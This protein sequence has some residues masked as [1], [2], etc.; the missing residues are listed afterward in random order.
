MA[1][2]PPASVLEFDPSMRIAVLYGKE[3]FLIE[4]HTRRLIEMLQE[5]FGGIEVFTFDGE[6]VQPA[7]VLDELRS[8]GLM[9]RH[10]L[11]ILNNAEMFLAGSK[12][13][14]AEADVDES[15]PATSA[16]AS[17]SRR[18]LMERYAENPVQD[19]TLLMRASTWRAG[20][21]DKVILKAGGVI[22]E[23]APLSSDKAAAWCIKRCEKRYG[24]TIELDAAQ[25]LVLRLGPELQHLDTELC[26]LAAMAGSRGM[27]RITRDI[28]AQAVGLSREEKAWEIQEAVV[29]GDAA[30]MLHKLRELM[31]VSR[32]D[33]VPIAWA[34]IDLLR[35]LYAAAQLMARGV[36]AGG[37]TSQLRLW[38]STI[39]PMLQIA[40]RTP[41]T[42][43]AQLLQFAIQTDLHSKSGVGDPRRNL[44]ALMVRIADDFSAPQG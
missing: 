32:Q 29:T 6:T 36:P 7:T 31:D 39:G 37:V 10:K 8:Y 44:E 24:A 9:Q 40:G 18:P 12:G 25:L 13:E 16:A 5:H 14:E 30:T 41:P 21:L 4:E 20:K 2:K 33:A 17:T 38:G 27:S 26:K 43:L 22:Y 23:C 11:V 42:R 34:I 1:K 19:A 35:K 15:G 28:V 3:R